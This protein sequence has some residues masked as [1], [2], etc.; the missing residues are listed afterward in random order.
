MAE[1]LDV[2][3][4][5]EAGGREDGKTTVRSKDAHTG[6]LYNDNDDNLPLRFAEP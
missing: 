1:K 6:R 5:L 2:D 3:G 4:G